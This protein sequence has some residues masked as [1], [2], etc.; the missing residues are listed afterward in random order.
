MNDYA[1][2]LSSEELALLTATPDSSLRQVERTQLIWLG[3]APQPLNRQVIE[4]QFD[5]W[6][7]LDRQSDLLASV[8][9]IIINPD[10]VSATEQ[11]QLARR[12]NEHSQVSIFLT[13]MPAMRFAVSDFIYCPKPDKLIEEL[14]NWLQRLELQFQSWANSKS[15]CYYQPRQSQPDLAQTLRGRSNVKAFPWQAPSPQFNT[16]LAQSQLMVLLAEDDDSYLVDWFEAF[17]QI[18]PRP[19][20]L[21]YHGYQ[22]PLL[23]SYL[24]LCRQLG[25]LVYDHLPKQQIGTHLNHVAVSAFRLYRYRLRHQAKPKGYLR[26]FAYGPPA[27][28]LQLY[29]DWPLEELRPEMTA[30]CSWQHVRR[31]FRDNAHPEQALAAHNAN[32][33]LIIQ[34]E[35]DL[36]RIGELI[37]LKQFGFR[38]VWEPQGFKQLE[39]SFENSELFD[40]VALP[41]DVWLQIQQIPEFNSHWQ[42]WVEKAAGL[43]QQ[44]ALV[45][46]QSL[47]QEWFDKGFD[48]LIAEKHS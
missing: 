18:H 9:G 37:R 1:N 21:I 34:G 40:M 23:T 19:P 43:S 14:H 24:T 33:L 47:N 12:L 22:S 26:Y 39:R 36:K 6:P 2:L 29:W 38:L 42:Q 16:M 30:A 46:V 3:L 44:L 41:F 28:G 48:W 4:H 25:I 27:K 5:D 11:T 20:L 7:S 13:A 8:D 31:A 45:G 17:A 15:I 32:L 10:A 35:N